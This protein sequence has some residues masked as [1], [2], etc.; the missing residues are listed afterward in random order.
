MRNRPF[1]TSWKEEP[2]AGGIQ[3]D[4]NGSMYTDHYQEGWGKG[5]VISELHGK[6]N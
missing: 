5:S 2:Q 1:S 6:E 4:N 3:A